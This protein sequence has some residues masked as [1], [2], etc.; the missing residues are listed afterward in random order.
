M[1][2]EQNLDPL[3]VWNSGTLLISA[4]SPINIALV[5]YWGKVDCSLIIPLNSSISMTL[6]PQDLCSTTTVY[7][8]K[9]LK[10][11]T[12]ELN[13]E[14]EKFSS[15]INKMIAVIKAQAQGVRAVDSSNGEEVLISKE[16]LLDPGN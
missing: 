10:E 4:I 2:T 11:N 7:L 9:N 15:R 13:G 5:K 14:V 6:S 8:S 1:E 16:E 12:L 3:P